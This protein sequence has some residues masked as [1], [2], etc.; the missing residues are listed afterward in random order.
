[1]IVEWRVHDGQRFYIVATPNEGPEKKALKCIECVQ[2]VQCIQ[3]IDRKQANKR[4]DGMFELQK[5]E[6][7]G[8][9]PTR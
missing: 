9:T 8:I 4:Q 7:E 3:H 5:A 1:V 2:C 6:V